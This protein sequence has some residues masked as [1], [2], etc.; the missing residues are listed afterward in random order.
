MAELFEMAPTSTI[1]AFG[2]QLL[3]FPTDFQNKTCF[4]STIFLSIHCWMIFIFKMAEIFKMAFFNF[5][6]FSSSSGVLY[7][8]L[9]NLLFQNMIY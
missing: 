7:F 4:G 9:L 5:L 1:F 8:K 2:P 3:Y 6:C